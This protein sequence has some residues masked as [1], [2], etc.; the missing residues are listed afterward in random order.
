[1]SY[2]TL[3]LER[4]RANEQAGIEPSVLDHVQLRNRDLLSA[5]RRRLH[6]HALRDLAGAGDS[7]VR[8]DGNCRSV[9]ALS[10]SACERQVGDRSVELSREVIRSLSGIA[11]RGP[12][13]RLLQR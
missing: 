5:W 2:R 9:G 4:F 1:M 7:Y 3:L 13:V 10:P 6:E 11:S 8:R 12:W